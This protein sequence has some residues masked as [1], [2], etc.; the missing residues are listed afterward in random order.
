MVI[1]QSLLG[2]IPL[3]IKWHHKLFDYFLQKFHSMQYLFLKKEQTKKKKKEQTCT[4]LTTC[5]YQKRRQYPL[6]RNLCQQTQGCYQNKMR[7]EKEHLLWLYD[8]RAISKIGSP[9]CWTRQLQ[10]PYC[11]KLLKAPFLFKGPIFSLQLAKQTLLEHLYY[12]WTIA[13]TRWH[14]ICLSTRKVCPPKLTT[15][16]TQ[17]AAK[18]WQQPRW[19]SPISY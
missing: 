2:M 19:P 16:S 8:T 4:L 1:V 7:K 15:T 14:K 3:Q 17:I 10:L 5:K 11:Q 13:V 12:I 18:N 6:H 9:N